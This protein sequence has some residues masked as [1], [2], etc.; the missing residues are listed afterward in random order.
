MAAPVPLPPLNFT[1]QLAQ[2][3]DSGLGDLGIGGINIGGASTAGAGG[4]AT[5]ASGGAG[6]AAGRGGLPS[7][8]NHWVNYAL[9]GLAVVVAVQLL[10]KGKNK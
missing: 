9:V 5:G 8:A 6:T 3:S 2:R 7:G 1:E 10:K 4:S